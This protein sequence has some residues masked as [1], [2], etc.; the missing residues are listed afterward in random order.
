MPRPLE[1]RSP[2]LTMSTTLT[3]GV[4][5]ASGFKSLEL[6]S[7]LF[8]LNFVQNYTI[9]QNSQRFE[10]FFLALYAF[11]SPCSAQP[12]VLYCTTSTRTDCY[13]TYLGGLLPYK[14][15]NIVKKQ[16]FVSIHQSKSRQ[17][18]VLLSIDDCI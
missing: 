8:V 4:E 1:Q 18:Q 17:Y 16:R 6:I 15:L 12:T 11:R 10:W 3:S 5:Y 14:E 7:I 2:S 9:S 13:L